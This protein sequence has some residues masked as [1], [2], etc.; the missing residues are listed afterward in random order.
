MSGGV[1]PPREVRTGKVAEVARWISRVGHPFAM[2]VAFALAGSLRAMPWPRAVA[3]TVWVAVCG[4]APLVVFLMHQVKQGRSNFDISTRE[5]RGPAYLLGLALGGLLIATS[6]PLGAP[7]VI[8]AS[9]ACALA[10]VTLAALINLKLK[11]SLHTAF[12]V[13]VTIGFSAID[14]RATAALGVLTAAVAWSR[15]YLRRHTAVEI[16]AGLVLGATM[17][18]VLLWIFVRLGSP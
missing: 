16:C 4:V 17:A 13:W 6:W 10:M 8:L 5:L 1:A 7:P 15:L 9:M 12:A 2:L 3:L 18:G 11:V 14:L